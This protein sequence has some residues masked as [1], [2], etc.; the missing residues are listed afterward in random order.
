[1]E[2]WDKEDLDAVLKNLGALRSA[3]GREVQD[4]GAQT[5]LSGGG[6][7]KNFCRTGATWSGS[8]R[9][10]KKKIFLVASSRNTT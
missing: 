3:M 6:G 2:T 8:R 10:R 5:R 7:Q 1:M 9:K 4:A